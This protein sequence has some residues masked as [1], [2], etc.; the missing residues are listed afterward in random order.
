MFHPQGPTFFELARQ[1]LSSTER[2]Y[3]L[4]APKF[5]YTPFRTPGLVLDCIPSQLGEANSIESALDVCCGTGAGMQMLRPLVRDRLAGIDMSQGML[6]VA[7]QNLAQHPGDARLE[8]VRGDALAL[9]FKN[10]FDLAV[11]FGAHGHILPR[12][13]DRFI[14]Q[15]AIALKPGGRFLFVS[16]Y[17]PPVWHPQWWLSRGFNAAMRVRNLLISPPFIMYYL[18]FLLPDVEQKLIK[19]GFSVEVRSGVFSRIGGLKL[20]IA[21]LR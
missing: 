7:E 4:L 19:H 18:T 16:G 11:C 2:G 5:D 10:E 21:T 17:L 13:E 12:D 15:I 6:A 20:V 14:E 9:P 8:F 1:A 3:D